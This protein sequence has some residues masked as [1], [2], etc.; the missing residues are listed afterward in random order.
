MPELKLQQCYLL[1]FII[2]NYKSNDLSIKKKWKQAVWK[3]T[4]ESITYY[5]Q[6]KSD[7]STPEAKFTECTFRGSN[8]PR[9]TKYALAVSRWFSRL[10]TQMRSDWWRREN[11]HGGE[12]VKEKEKHIVFDPTTLKKCSSLAHT[13]SAQ[14]KTCYSKLLSAL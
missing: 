4:F 3:Q 9:D 6:N 1:Y 13:S 14:L 12:R 7:S 8:V 11:K 5:K 10:V 2:T